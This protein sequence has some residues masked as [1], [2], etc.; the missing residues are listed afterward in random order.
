MNGKLKTALTLGALIGLSSS[1]FVFSPAPA[2]ALDDQGTIVIKATEKSTIFIEEIRS[3][4]GS[5]LM[6]KYTD[7]THGIVCYSRSSLTCVKY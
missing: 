5:Y 2:R 4:T 1:Y 3:P 7:I 6:T